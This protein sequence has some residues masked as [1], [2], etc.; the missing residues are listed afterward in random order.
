MAII[1]PAIL[2]KTKEGFETKARSFERI[3]G[4]E[5]IQVDFC[6]GLFVPSV[7]VEVKDL[8]VL[9]P[10]FEWEAHLML[11]APM[12]FFEYQIAGFTTIII[13][14]E[15]FIDKVQLG[16]ELRNIHSLGLRAGLAVNPETE[17]SQ[18][19]H[20]ADVV[21]QF[22][23]LGVYPGSQG[24]DIIPEVFDRI[25]G[26]RKLLPR[27]IIEVDGGVRAD[28][29]QKIT[30]AGGDVV[31]VGSALAG[32]PDWDFERLRDAVSK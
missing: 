28:N 27:A 30:E 18:L 12:D 2:E 32:D 6:D 7:T 16:R 25:K 23:V 29:I 9:N 10:A 11:K 31:V 20:Y 3:S 13:H 1:V 17:L 19:S 4:V 21:D 24:Q 22:T 14:F 5:R 8:D 15:A 26:L